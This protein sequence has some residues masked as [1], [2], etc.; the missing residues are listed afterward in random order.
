VRCVWGGWGFGYILGTFSA[1]LGCSG[2]PSPMR[3]EREVLHCRW[4]SKMPPRGRRAHCMCGEQEGGG[5]KGRRRGVPQAQG[6]HFR[7]H[8][9]RCTRTQWRTQLPPSRPPPR[10][11]PRSG[12]ISDRAKS[13]VTPELRSQILISPRIRDP[14]FSARLLSFTLPG[15]FPGR[16]S[17]GFTPAC[18]PTR[19][20]GQPPADGTHFLRPTRVWGQPRERHFNPRHGFGGSLP[21]TVPPNHR[22]VWY[23]VN[24]TLF[25]GKFRNS[26]CCPTETGKPTPGKKRKGD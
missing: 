23:G 5:G 20:W 22:V 10:R 3:H 7:G 8:T 4:Y 16:N 17:R 11:V 14:R 12:V 26:S 21:P 15:S 1:H 2:T 19:V 6:S 25:G 13:S 9:L 24:F 18:P